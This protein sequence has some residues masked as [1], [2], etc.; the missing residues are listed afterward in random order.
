[1]AVDL[2]GDTLR[3]LAP[4]DDYFNYSG[5]WGNPFYVL[6]GSLPTVDRT[7]LASFGNAVVEVFDARC[8]FDSIDRATQELQVRGYGRRCLFGLRIAY[9]KGGIRSSEEAQRMESSFGFKPA[10]FATDQEVRIVVGF[11]GPLSTSPTHLTLQLEDPRS[12]C[13]RA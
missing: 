4:V 3:M 2:D 12:F 7:H 8:M 10:K 6:C 1:V 9:D 5:D 13:R 11:N